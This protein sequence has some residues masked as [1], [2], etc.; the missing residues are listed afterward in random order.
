MKVPS[1]DGVLLSDFVT[2]GWFEPTEADRMDFKRRVSQTLELAAGGYMSIFDAAKG[3]KQ[4][5]A[6]EK[7]AEAPVGSRR[8][9]RAMS[10]E[11]WERSER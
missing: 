6:G 3:W 7:A 8:Q 9:R 2:P 5:S 4:I 11:Q 10:R 1:Y